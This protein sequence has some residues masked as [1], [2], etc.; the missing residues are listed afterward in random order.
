MATGIK[1]IAEMAGVSTT[2]VSHVVNGTRFVSED[3]R[4]RVLLAM[5]NL[6]YRPNRMASGLRRRQSNTIG[7][8]LPDI[9]NPYFAEVARGVEDACFTR[10]YSA[11]ICNSDASLKTEA[12]CLAML[13]EKQTDGIVLV[14]AGG[15]APAPPGG[16]TRDIPLV[17][18]DREVPGLNVDFIQVDNFAG[19]RMAA[20][21]FLSLGHRHA[22][23]I[24]GSPGVYP[25]WERVD[26]FLDAMREAGH[27]VPEELVLAGDF[28][29]ESGY[30]L[31]GKLMRARPR[32]TAIFAANDLMAYGVIRLL[33]EMG[34]HVP[35]NV[36]VIGFD[37]ISL[38][39]LFNPPLT[40]VSQPRLDM[41][42]MAVRLLLERLARPDLEPRRVMLPLQL[43]PRQSSGFAK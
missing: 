15:H 42:G 2:T 13:A 40:T 17:M 20:E 31:A 33:T 30:A 24:G 22:A 36:S 26:G 4:Q 37:D 32:P 43:I 39:A 11:I 9:T 29:A 6:N 19:G 5:R 34:L 28:Q 38:S 21:Q 23:C 1:L 27:P 18:L 7:V 41:G 10:D 16:M 35:N 12:R 14:N 3:K 25:P 8:V